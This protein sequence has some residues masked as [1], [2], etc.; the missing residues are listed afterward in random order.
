MAE[1]GAAMG[2]ADSDI[3]D[4]TAGAEGW[5]KAGDE[6]MEIGIG[7]GSCGM[8]EDR[9]VSSSLVGLSK[10]SRNSSISAFVT[11]GA[12]ARV[13]FDVPDVTVPKTIL[14]HKAN[15]FVAPGLFH[16]PTRSFLYAVKFEP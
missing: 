10:A 12:E 6:S 13:L 9:G 11:P 15:S 7:E 2:T 1:I 16:N 14:F 3:V 4:S 5:V 8:A